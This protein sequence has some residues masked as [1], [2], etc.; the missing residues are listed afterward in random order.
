MFKIEHKEWENENT[1]TAPE[2]REIKDKL[3]L[4]V[5]DQFAVE[6]TNIET[7]E[8]MKARK[9]N[10]NICFIIVCPLARDFC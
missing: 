8:A 10:E 9:N 5:F 6:L 1:L 4:G 3:K 7:Q 2:D